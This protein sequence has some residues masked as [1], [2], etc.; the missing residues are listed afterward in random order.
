MSVEQDYTP[1]PE[2]NTKRI[3]TSLRLPYH[4][5][6]DI[7][8]NTGAVETLCQIGGIAS[9]SICND[10]GRATPMIV[11]VTGSGVALGGF[12]AESM[13]NVNNIDG[14]HEHPLSA[15]WS[16]LEVTINED[17][18]IAKLEK[19]KKDLKSPTNWAGIVD[20]SVKDGVAIAAFQNLVKNR[21]SYIYL[22]GVINTFMV[23]ANILGRDY[24]IATFLISAWEFMDK[25]I[26][27]NNHGIEKPGEGNR[28][29][30]SIFQFPELD[31][32]VALDLVMPFSKLA[33]KISEQ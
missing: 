11:G 19:R 6:S 1:L 30:L 13:S 9:I 20:N 23:G 24:S 27:I 26:N 18:S 8:L 5:E 16:T 21:P 4:L 25:A 7:G 22:V 12:A 33:K 15:R 10:N 3:R 29:S 14:S 28:W 31:R 17:V 2:A 32:M